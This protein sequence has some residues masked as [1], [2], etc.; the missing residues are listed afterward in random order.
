MQA[1][2]A[3][4][5]GSALSVTGIA[6]AGGPPKLRREREKQPR[7]PATMPGIAQGLSGSRGMPSSTRTALGESATRRGPVLVA[8]KRICSFPNAG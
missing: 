7:R 6:G 8:V 5:G 1:D 3:G 2:F 4:G